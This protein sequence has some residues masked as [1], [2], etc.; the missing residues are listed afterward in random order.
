M[1]GCWVSIVRSS[2]FHI[3]GPYGVNKAETTEEYHQSF[4]QNTFYMMNDAR[5]TKESFG[6]K[7]LG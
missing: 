2:S 4:K 1:W 7:S 6:E 5:G 3:I